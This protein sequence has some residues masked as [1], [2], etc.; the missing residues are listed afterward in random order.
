MSEKNYKSRDE[1]KVVINGLEFSAFQNLVYDLLKALE[2]SEIKQ[3]GG[4]AD[5]GRDLEAYFVYRR[6]NG[7]EFKA[8]CWIQCKKQASG[9][10]FSQIHEDITRAS[11]QRVDEYYILSNYDTTPDC[12]D[13]LERGQSSWFCKIVDWTGLKVQDI[14]FA[15]PDICKYY[16]PDEEVPP[17]TDV[18]KPNEAIRLSSEIGKRFGIGL[19]LKTNKQVDLNNPTE[20]AEVLKDAL[21]KIRDIDINLQAL[22][23]QKISMFFFGLERAEDALMFLNRALEITPKNVETLLNKGFILEKIDKVKESNN[24]YDEILAIDPNNKFALNNKA[25]NLIRIGSFEEALELA[26]KALE[27]DPNFIHAIGSKVNALK[28][29]KKL[30]E[31]LAFL[32]E[33]KELMNKSINLQIAKVDLCMELLDL[34]EAY[35]INEEILSKNPDRIDAMN[36]KG[37][38][39]EKNSKFQRRDKYLQLSMNCFEQ[40]IEKDNKYPLGWS[41]KAVVLLNSNQVE[42]AEKIIDT[43]YIMFPKSP[44]VLNKKGVVLHVKMKPKDAI[45]YFNRALRLRFEEEFLL[46]RAQAQLE[47]NHF[48]EAKKDAEALLKYNPKKSEAWAIKG[49]AL[50]KLHQPTKAS[51][52]F[53]K[54]EEY[55]EKPISLLESD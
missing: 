8:K 23:Y 18:R 28:G 1:W 31:A 41:N 32:N 17:V 47:L 37:V 50:K 19:E 53:K 55:E 34:K 54:A 45:T 14:L 48:K 12:K 39:F 7:D 35:K 29:L 16:F 30:D 42:D 2:F 51:I 10:A 11:I 52:C 46:N 25:S 20:V 9:V 15:H 3:R 49:W 43:A 36:Y 13:E 21:L 22:I 44:Y 38:I 5:G 33:K 26:N 6:P 24:C 40:V 4:G 27:S